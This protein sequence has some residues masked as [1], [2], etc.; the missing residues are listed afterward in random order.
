[1]AKIEKI[2]FV[3]DDYVCSFLNVSLVEEL[4]LAKEVKA[5]Y[6][7]DEALAYIKLHYTGKTAEPVAIPDLIFLDIKMPGLNGFELL[8][9]L[10]KNKN[11][12]RSRFMV[13]LLTTMLNPSDEEQ[14]ICSGEKIHT[15]L[16]K[17]LKEEDMQKLMT[18]MLAH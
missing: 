13:I 18:E 8:K 9:E 12:D 2:L 17:P 14:T 3:D 7:A 1:M 6:N 16:I 5:V 10:D 4:G 11:I 15:C